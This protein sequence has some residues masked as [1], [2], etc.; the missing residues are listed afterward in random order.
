MDWGAYHRFQGRSI[1]ASISEAD[2]FISHLVGK[3]LTYPAALVV[4][5]PCI[6]CIDKE[7]LTDCIVAFLTRVQSAGFYVAL[8]CDPFWLTDRLS[9]QKLRQFDI[10]LSQ[11]S[12]AITFQESPVY[13]WQYSLTGSVP[14]ICGDVN[15]DASFKNYPLIIKSFYMNGFSKSD[16][17]NVFYVGDRV[18]MVGKIY[19][20]PDGTTAYTPYFTQLYIVGIIENTKRPYRL[21]VSPCGATAG[22]ACASDM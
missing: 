2:F 9:F 14:G 19:K 17:D 4:N 16:S 21:S 11:P 15:L 7:S 6:L 18:S 1:P 12:P 8:C 20:T 10:W 22:F 13:I 3:R 5:D